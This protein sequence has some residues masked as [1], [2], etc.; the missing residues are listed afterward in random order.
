MASAEIWLDDRDTQLPLIFDEVLI[1][2]V[3]STTV[4]VGVLFE[5]IVSVSTI[6][7]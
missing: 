7:I 4:P 2:R 1:A 3:I 6:L 5:V